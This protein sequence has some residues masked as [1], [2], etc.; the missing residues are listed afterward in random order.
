MVFN[1]AATSASACV[2]LFP[3]YFC[4]AL[5]TFPLALTGAPFPLAFGFV[6]LGLGF[7]ANVF[8]GAVIVSSSDSSESI[9]S[10]D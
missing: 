7:A 10:C 6:V 1:N 3:F 8:F 5:S 4:E 9:E 2:S